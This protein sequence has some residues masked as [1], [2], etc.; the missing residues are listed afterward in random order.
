MN[1]VL[2]FLLLYIIFLQPE[3]IDGPLWH[4]SMA[5]FDSNK[6]SSEWWKSILTLP[7]EVNNNKTIDLSIW[8][9]SVEIGLKS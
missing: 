6:C 1:S 3:A 8:S 2:G 4:G 7:G 9:K 5:S